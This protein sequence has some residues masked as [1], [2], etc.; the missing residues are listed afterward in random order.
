LLC[1]ICSLGGAIRGLTILHLDFQVRE[2]IIL[3]YTAAGTN[4]TGKKAKKG[5]KSQMDVFKK[6][7]KKVKHPRLRS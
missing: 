4:K 1:P 6:G 3:V 7:A 5:N 2:G